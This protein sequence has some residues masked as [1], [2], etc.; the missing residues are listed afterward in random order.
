[1][2]ARASVPATGRNRVVGRA[3]GGGRR[4]T[5]I[6]SA[7]ACRLVR[8]F[9]GLGESRVSLMAVTDVQGLSFPGRYCSMVI[10]PSRRADSDDIGR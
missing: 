5:S 4:R 7:S 9:P 3:A 8:R 1:M 6:S 10:S 2:A